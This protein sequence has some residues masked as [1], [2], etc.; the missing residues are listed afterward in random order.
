MW[1]KSRSLPSSWALIAALVLVPLPSPGAERERDPESSPVAAR[2]AD[3][4]VTRVAPGLVHRVLRRGGITDEWRYR[5]VAGSFGPGSQ[6]EADALLERLQEA[7]HEPGVRYEGGRYLV[8]V[9][10]F[11]S[12]REAERGARRLGDEGLTGAFPLEVYGQDLT[13]PAGPWEI[14]LLEADPRLVRVEV[15]SAADAAIGLET[16]L[17]LASRRGAVAAINGGYFRMTGLTRGDATGLLQL[18]GRLLSETDRGRAAV[19]FRE[20]EGAVEPVFGR[21]G[22]RGRVVRSDGFELRLDGINRERRPDEVVLFTPEFHRTTLTSPGGLE[23]VARDGRIRQVLREKGS[24]A[25]PRDGFVVSIGPEEASAAAD[26]P[27]GLALLPELE[28]VARMGEPV[29]DWSTTRFAVGGGPLLLWNGEAREDWSAESISK[30]FGLVRH[31]RTAFGVREDGTLL[32]L[33]VDGRAPR[34]SVGMSLPELTELLGDLGA[35]SAINLDGGGST[36]MVLRDRVVNRPSDGGEERWNGDA[37][38]L[39][40]RR[41]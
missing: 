40:E 18:D 23:V 26:W 33:T 10:P 39:F 12:R 5:V 14:H 29:P 30:V 37:L 1:R 38:L 11:A 3:G 6:G 28:I 36:T 2:A 25:I 22:F 20:A 8:T 24:V 19:G 35:V 9:G 7:G 4:E 15:A 34:R 31:P 32:F 21:P 16:T 41:P 13:N 27:R 17:S